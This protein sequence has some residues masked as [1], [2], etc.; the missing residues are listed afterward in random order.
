ML[1]LSGDSGSLSWAQQARTS[2][3]LATLLAR[4][5]DNLGRYRK[6]VPSFFCHEHIVSEMRGRKSAEVREYDS[7]FR[8]RKDVAANGR[9]TFAEARDVTRENGA[10]VERGTVRGP[11]MVEGVFSG[12]LRTVSSDQ[13]A[14]MAYEL[15]DA[16]QRTAAEPHVIT[17]AARE[18]RPVY[19]CVLNEA[20]RGSVRVDAQTMQVTHLEFVAPDH[21]AG[22]GPV[23]WKVALDYAPVD[24]GGAEYW[25]PRKI[26]S[27]VLPKSEDDQTTG[28]FTA[29]YDG[30]H[31]LN[32]TSR[33][34]PVE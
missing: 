16:S 17:F 19:G 25:I 9:V 31:K 7:V 34:V 6:D 26:A 2:G 8:V 22:Y 1:V 18:K 33:V 14:C 21:N 20:A 4:L 10:P 30:C 15:A 28:L 12:G 24:L 5:D 13:S 32:V 3:Q 23:V 27:A 11:V 29:T